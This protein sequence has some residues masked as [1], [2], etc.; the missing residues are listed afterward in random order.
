LIVKAYSEAAGMSGLIFAMPD[1]CATCN[2]KDV[3]HGKRQKF[4]IKTSPNKAD[5]VLAVETTKVSSVES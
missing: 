5:I 3:P 4:N 2:V 1:E